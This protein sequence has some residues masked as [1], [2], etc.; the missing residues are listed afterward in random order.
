M[1][2]R[3]AVLFLSGCLWWHSIAFLSIPGMGCAV[4]TV[5]SRVSEN[6]TQVPFDIPV[7]TTSLNLGGNR[8]SRLTAEDFSRLVALNELFLNDNVITLIEPAA[9][10]NLSQLQFLWLQ[11]NQIPRLEA[12]DFTGLLGLE[13]LRLDDNVISVIAQGTFGD[14]STLRELNLN[15]NR[16]SQVNTESFEGLTNLIRLNIAENLD[17]PEG[18]GECFVRYLPLHVECTIFLRLLRL[19]RIPADIGTSTTILRI[20]VNNITMVGQDDL[21]Q[22]VALKELHLDTNMITRIDSQAFQSL[23]R[24][25]RI[26]LTDNRITS[27]ERGTFDALK[28]LKRLDLNE[29]SIAE[30]AP[31]LFSA[32]GA[33]DELRLHFN[34][35]RVLQNDTFSGLGNLT[36]L[37]IHFNNITH[38]E[39]GSFLPLVRVTTLNLAHNSL[40]E[41]P[42]Y[43]FQGLG[44]LSLLNISSNP[45]NCSVEG[46]Q[47]L[48]YT[49]AT[50]ITSTTTVPTVTTSLVLTTSETDSQAAADSAGDPGDSTTVVVLI[51]LGAVCG[52]IMIVGLLYFVQKSRWAHQRRSTL[53]ERLAMGDRSLDLEAQAETELQIQYPSLASEGSQAVWRRCVVLPNRLE[54]KPKRL[55]QG[56]FGDVFLGHLLP[57]KGGM[58][59]PVAVKTLRGDL[60]ASDQTQFLMEARLMAL[61]THSNLLRL[62]AVV[63]QGPSPMIVTELMPRGDLKGVL[64]AARR[65][66]SASEDELSLATLLGMATSLC[67]AVV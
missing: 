66:A 50:P 61:L 1:G 44:Q 28:V 43:L 26:D 45:V 52:T 5:I 10:Q 34:K 67:D 6:L 42:E 40:W 2:G 63:L 12:G 35:L 56:A 18:R 59:K 53:T 58:G 41:L 20:D 47:P 55:G 38:I 14:L 13:T 4:G 27:I 17:D 46:Y 33:L 16:L 51:I 60:S 54:L 36:I 7:E 39:P 19:S 11:R 22:L 30:L 9:F 24:L 37:P 32:L 31:G 64:R 57:K 48:E 62:E 49:C 8:I 3:R 65:S 29:N 21:S 23:V 25:E 15:S